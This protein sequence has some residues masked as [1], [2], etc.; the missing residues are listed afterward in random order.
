MHNL[1]T[2]MIKSAMTWLSSY[3]GIFMTNQLFTFWLPV[4]TDFQINF[5][6]YRSDVVECGIWSGSTLFAT[7]PAVFKHVRWALKF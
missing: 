4:W 3:G 1:F 5:H 6:M 2:G 7:H